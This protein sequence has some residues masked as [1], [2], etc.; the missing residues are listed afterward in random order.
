MQTMGSRQESRRRVTTFDD[1]DDE[2]MIHIARHVPLNVSGL[3]RLN[4]RARRLHLSEYQP[5][6]SCI[7]LTNA[8]ELKRYAETSLRPAR[9]F[10]NIY[11]SIAFSTA[12]RRAIWCLH[13]P[14]PSRVSYHSSSTPTPWFR[15]LGQGRPELVLSVPTSRNSFTQDVFEQLV[16][17][18]TNNQHLIKLGFEAT[19]LGTHG[20]ESIARGISTSASLTEVDL[21]DNRLGAAGS[22]HIAEG[23]SAS[24]SLTQVLAFLFAFS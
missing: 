14:T 4:L 11:P 13:A 23:M 16:E 22:K 7:K 3:S 18:I 21:R 6:L 10:H 12:C 20:G 9:P 1:L 15:C 19:D 2:T 5:L 8:A 24:A 17:Q